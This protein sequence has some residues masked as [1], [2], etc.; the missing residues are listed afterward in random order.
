MIT[1]EI[2]WIIK[3]FFLCK[4]G[5]PPPHVAQPYFWRLCFWQILI[6]TFWTEG[7][8]F[9]GKLCFRRWFLKIWATH[10]TKKPQALKVVFFFGMG[11]GVYYIQ[12]HNNAHHY[13]I[14]KTKKLIPI[15]FVVLFVICVK[16]QFFSAMLL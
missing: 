9:Q 13:N 3:M 14:F 11:G 10:V 2:L 15:S 5:T 4:F 16:T 1:F 8:V 12:A 7:T 6:Y